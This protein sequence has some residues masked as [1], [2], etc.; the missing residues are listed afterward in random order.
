MIHLSN[1]NFPSVCVQYIIDIAVL[2]FLSGIPT[3]V[4]QFGASVLAAMPAIVFAQ[5]SALLTVV[6]VFGKVKKDVIDSSASAAMELMTSNKILPSAPGNSNSLNI[7]SYI[8]RRFRSTSLNILL[9]VL[10]FALWFLLSVRST[11]YLKNNGS[12]FFGRK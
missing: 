10:I 11:E 7:T 6:P 4:Y 12:L 1:R 5:V 2:I 8:E 9:A 3:H